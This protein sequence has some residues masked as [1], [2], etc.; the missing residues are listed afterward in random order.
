MDEMRE[1][2]AQLDQQSQLIQAIL[3]RLVSARRLEVRE[4]LLAKARAPWKRGR[5]EPGRAATAIDGAV[6]HWPLCLG[7]SGDKIF[8]ALCKV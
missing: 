4:S 6:E 7:T 8:R 5:E 2:L 3:A 1:Q